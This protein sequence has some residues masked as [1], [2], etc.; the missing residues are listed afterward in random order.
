MRRVVLISCV[1]KKLACA[2][3]AAQLYISPLFR[4]SLAYARQLQPDAIY[5]LSAKHGLVPLDQVLKPYEQTL[6][7][8]TAIERADWG[9][10]VLA[11]LASRCELLSDQFTI[12]A[13]RRYT[14]PLLPAL[15]DHHLPLAGLGQGRRLHF[16]KT[17]LHA[18]S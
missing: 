1:K 17:A 3:P 6:R 9:Q 11:Q 4:F 5:I 8:M 13:G 10:K 2:A 14:E 16:L 18:Q 7:T 15:P 12:L